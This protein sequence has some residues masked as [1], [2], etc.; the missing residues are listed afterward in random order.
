ML[1][2]IPKSNISKRNF[3]VYKEWSLSNSDYAVVSASN[4]YG[5][6]NYSLWNSINS[7][8]YNKN[9][10]AI[11]LFGRVSN[12]ANLASER[13]ITNT[14]YTI[15]IPQ[16]LY[17]EGIKS[18]TITLV[19]HNSD[20][21]YT[22]DGKGNMFSSIP[23]YTLSSIDFETGQLTIIDNDGEVYV[24]TI[25][26]SSPFDFQSGQMTVT[27]GTD[28]DV[29]NIVQFDFEAG[30]MK[31]SEPLDFDGLSIDASQ[32]GNIFY[33]DGLLVINE[34]ITSYS[35]DYRSTKTIYETEVL[36]SSKA[37]EFNTSQS[38]SAVDVVLTN[39]Y[40]F[41]TTAIPN[42]KSAETIK[43]KEIGDIKLK[44][45]IAGSYSSSLS[46]SWDDYHTSASIDPTGSYLAPFITTIGLYDDDNNMIAVAK[47]PKPIK[48]LPDYDVNFI[49]R[50]DT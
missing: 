8:Y 1:K 16:E 3:K 18:N 46:G 22:D 23:E 31:V 19:N 42:V 14:I 33:E 37:G 36:V 28:T 26:P 34:L 40:D 20:S 39:S 21:I 10:T 12:F 11:T 50:F 41:T 43:I 9:A 13:A 30:L 38:P 35:L 24:G 48:N 27:F 45:T 47:L 6:D 29:V 44:P 7:K 2:T 5:T 15:A 17:G 49:V 25:H 32:F 4:S